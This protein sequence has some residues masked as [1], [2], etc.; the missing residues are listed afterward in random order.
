MKL[1]TAITLL[2]VLVV[3]TFALSA[4]GGDKVK[5]VDEP[6]WVIRGSGAFEGDAGRVFYGVGAASGIKNKALSR[7]TADN[8]ARAE[9]QKVFKTYSASLMKDYM[10]STTAGDMSA[11]SEEQHVEQAVKTFSAGTLHGVEIVNH[12]TDP[13][14]GT[15]YSLARLDMEFFKDA[16]QKMNE[17]SAEVRDYV[18]KNAERSFDDLAAEEAKHNM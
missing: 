17:L 5:K 10:A 12:W 8:R 6:E 16:L 7:T 1:K 3:A 18:R 2:L 14:D 13:S 11:S 4:C 15:L 9:I